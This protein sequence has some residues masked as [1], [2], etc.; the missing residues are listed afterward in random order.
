MSSETLWYKKRI[1][2]PLISRGPKIPPIYDWYRIALTMSREKL[3]LFC[4]LC[5]LFIISS[6]GL[7]RTINSQ[8]LV[9]VPARGGSLTEGVIGAPRFVNPLLAVSQADHDLTELIYA[10]LMRLRSDGTLGPELAERYEMSEDGLSYTFYLRPNLSWHDGKPLTTNDVLFTINRAMDPSLKSPKRPSWEGV[11][12][13]ALD[14]R[15]VRFHLAQPF[16]S[17]LENATIGIL[18]EHIWGSIEPDVF[19]FSLWNSGAVGS[20]PYEVSRVTKDKLGIPLYYDLIPFENYALGPAH[21]SELRIRFYPNDDALRSALRSSEVESIA[22]ISSSDVKALATDSDNIVRAKLPR[23]F[24]VFFNQ[25]QAPI[26][27]DSSVRKAL[28]LSLSRSFIVANALNNYAH[29][30]TSPLPKDAQEKATDEGAVSTQEAED[31]GKAIAMLDNAGWKLNEKTGVRSKGGKELAFT[32]V[33]ANTPELRDVATLIKA[34]WEAIGAR[35]TLRVFELSDLNQNII[36]PRKY[37]ALFFGEVVGREPDLFSFWHSSQRNDPGLNVAL[38]TNSR[39]D[40]LLDEARRTVDS[41]E[42][43]KLF[44]KAA[45]IIKGDV[46]A[47]FVYVPE[48]LYLLPKKVQGVKVSSLTT[49]TE[50]FDTI[51]NWYI[52]TESVW[53]YFSS[54]HR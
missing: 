10:G 17:F 2:L 4:V 49:A 36:R 54:S 44:E 31:K 25:N 5:L 18:P 7:L 37:D 13:E 41:E 46:P 1:E 14:E 40:K 45:E 38:Y 23:V 42:R 12:V 11:T 32:L 8:F 52:E 34:G 43:A 15:T 24:G 33:T 28:D 47:T 21:I 26:F 22:A 3:A 35:V 19:P 20:G 50:R 16:A 9:T 51:N 6:I 29:K 27:A 48:F 53:K 39:T 30:T